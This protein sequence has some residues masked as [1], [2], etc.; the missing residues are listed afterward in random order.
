MKKLLFLFFLVLLSG[1][2]KGQD[3]RLSLFIHTTPEVVWVND[4]L[5]IK[6]NKMDL[7]EGNH[8]IRA[9]V[10]GYSPLDTVIAIKAAE[11]KQ[12]FYRFDRSEAYKTWEK[13]KTSHNNKKLIRFGL[14]VA[15]TTILTGTMIYTFFSA[16]NKHQEVLDKYDDYI[17]SISNVSSAEADFTAAQDSYRRTYW[18]YYIQAGALAVS[19]YFLYKGIVWLQKNTF[20][21]FVSEEN[22]FAFNGID[23]KSDPYTGGINLCLIFN[24][25]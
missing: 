18:S 25:D 22:P 19:A 6:G 9:W 13:R 11:N 2:I 24:L 5:L 23:I 4:S 10:P 15:T 8:R 7:P 14:P 17:N 20:P 16:R 1:F 3:A 21:D 12:F